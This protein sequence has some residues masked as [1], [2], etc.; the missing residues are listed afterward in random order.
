MPFTCMILSAFLHLQG[1]SYHDPK[2]KKWKSKEKGEETDRKK[3]RGEEAAL[4]EAGEQI[5]YAGGRRR[6]PT[7]GMLG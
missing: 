1:N 4:K 5:L 3:E 6:A 2:T 7:R